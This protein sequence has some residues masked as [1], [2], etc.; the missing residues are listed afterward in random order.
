MAFDEV[1]AAQIRALLADEPDVTEK[2]MFGGLA[3]LVAGN[4]AVAASSGGGMLVRVEPAASEALVDVTG[5]SLMEMR[6]RPMRGWL[7]IRPEDLQAKRDVERWVGEGLGFART[8]P[9]KSR[10]G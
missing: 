4:M 10:G 7:R 5:A 1:V 6:G 9:P 8:L 2:E 3:F